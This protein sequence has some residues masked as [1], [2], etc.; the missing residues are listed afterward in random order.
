V[1]EVLVGAPPAAPPPGVE[2]LP[3]NKVGQQ[4]M[5]VRERMVAHRADPSCNSCHGI[6]DPLGMALEN[7]DGVGMWRD[8]DR[9]AGV[10]IDSA[11]ALPD[12][13][14]VSGPDDLRAALMRHPDQFVQNLTQRL[15]VF[16]LG[17]EVEYHD[18]PAVRAIVRAA[19]EDD[20]RFVS[21][22]EGIVTSDQF[23]MSTAPEQVA[24]EADTTQEAALH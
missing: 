2:A 1:L 12:G 13:A 3:E 10:P 14:P 21:L 11:G 19:G 18:M 24:E 17:R 7:F 15:M 22:V 16:A 20:Y 23:R 5:T 6:M 8:N 9:F 4:A